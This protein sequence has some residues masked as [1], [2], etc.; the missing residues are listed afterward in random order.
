MVE[1]KS[2]LYKNKVDPEKKVL[3]VLIQS[4]SIDRMESNDPVIKE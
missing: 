4:G 2:T 3:Q 1:R